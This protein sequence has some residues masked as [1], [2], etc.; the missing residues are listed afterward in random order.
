MKAQDIREFTDYLHACTN[1]QVIG[2]YNKEK[3]A[4]RKKYTELAV[5]EA[6]RRGIDLTKDT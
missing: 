4:G 3:K 1:N 5:L 2:V 6:Q